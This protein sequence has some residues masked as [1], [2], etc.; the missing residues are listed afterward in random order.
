MQDPIPY[1]C[2]SV[3]WERLIADYPPPGLFHQSTGQLSDDA[4]RALQETRF[5]QRM[6]EAWRIGFYARR[7]RAAGLEPGDVRGLD[8]LDKIPTFNSDDLRDA[9]AEEPPFG[10]HHPL[11]RATLG[12]V[13]LK[14]QTSGGTTGLPRFT[15]FDPLAWE[16]QAILTARALYAQGARPGDVVEITYTNSLANA[17]WC[18]T[19]ALHHWLGCVPVTAGSGNV[20]S[21]ERHLEYARTL[22]VNGWYSRGEYLARL[23]EVARETGF[24]L[25]Q[26]PTRYIHSFLGP[27]VEGHLRRQLEEA[28]GAP[29]YDNYG[30]HEIGLVAFECEAKDGMHLSED[31]VVVQTIDIDSGTPLPLGAKGSSVFTS[32]HRSVPPFIRYDLR[33]V[34]IQS[35]RSLCG[36]GLRT[37]KLST[38]LGRA[39]EMI[40]LRG[41]NVFPLACQSAVTADPRN[42]GDYICVVSHKGE[43]LARR[44]EMVVRIERRSPDIDADSLA[45]DMRRAL[46]RDLGVKVDVE[47]VEAGSLSPLTGLGT[48]NKVKRLLDLR[49]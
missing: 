30:T 47:I 27:D 2:W 18:G 40:K 11:S 5:L 36:C 33:D 28:W 45:Q 48:Q 46:H 17:A 4:L 44:E 41:T 6:G 3:D 21:S 15:L 20:T 31:C 38:F 12:E 1:Y 42:S 10:S 29:V 35:E 14:L 32:L 39:D 34:L 49:R 19:N 23:T 7:W 9:I 37:R 26:L 16:V 24:D 43:G 8:D 22:G 13:P 25:H